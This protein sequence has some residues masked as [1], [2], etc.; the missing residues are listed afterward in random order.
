MNRQEEYKE[1]KNSWE[2]AGEKAGVNKGVIKDKTK[3]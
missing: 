1:D 2:E 3:V